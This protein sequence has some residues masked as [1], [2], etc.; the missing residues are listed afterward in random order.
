MQIS[1]EKFKKDY[2]K[3]KLDELAE[4]YG[5][6]KP[7]IYSYAKKL[8]LSKGSGRLPKLNIS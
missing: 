7:T 6:S 5:V 8:G 4:K 2:N 1:K 3:M